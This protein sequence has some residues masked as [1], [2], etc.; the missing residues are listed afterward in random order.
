MKKKDLNRFKERLLDQK[1]Q[2]IQSS[3]RVRSEQLNVDREDLPDEL[4][5]ASSE[6]TKSLML[7]LN[8]RERA[9]LP[10]ID[11]ALAKISG[12]DYG[13]C[14]ECEGDI[15]VSRLE[16]RPFAVLCIKCKE[17]EEHKEKLYANS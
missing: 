11:K 1:R 8:D 6:L 17:E 12:G 4:D 14:E 9:V 5:Q 10:K 13:T 16:V 2:I 15:G 3:D 7:R